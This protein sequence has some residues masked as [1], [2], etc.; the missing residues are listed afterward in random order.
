VAMKRGAS[1]LVIGGLLVLVLTGC[2]DDQLTASGTIEATQVALAAEMAGR[3]ELVAVEEG[4]VVQKDD[5]LVRLDQGEARL[6]YQQAA[7]GQA[8]AEAR[9]QEAEAGSRP[10]QLREAEQAVAQA[11]AVRDQAAADLADLEALLAEGAVAQITV[12]Q[13]RT[14]YETAEAAYRAAVARRDLVAAGATAES[15]AAL[16]AQVEQ[17]R[18]ATAL[19]ALRLERSEIKAPLAGTVLNC[20]AV[21]GEYVLPGAPVVTIA[22][23]EKL[24]LRVYVKE[25]DLGRVSVGQQ[26]QLQVD[27]F[28]GEYFP[29]HITRIA[30]RAEFTP[31]NMQTKEARVTTVYEVRVDVDQ[32]QERL[33]PGMPADVFFAPLTDVG[34]EGD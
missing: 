13:A 1:W 30:D 2:Q 27:S 10:Q 20:D 33:R 23:L 25:S 5:L 21:E 16:R 8:V 11:Q 17:A 3:V 28:P 31:K 32:G 6:A 15:L 22:D 9:L 24:W 14:G 12:A 19:A 26:V 34:Q 4:D 18:A 29:G 7:A